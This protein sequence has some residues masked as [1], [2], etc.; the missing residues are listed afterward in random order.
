VGGYRPVGQKRETYLRVHLHCIMIIMWK[1]LLLDLKLPLN[2]DCGNK[3]V[4]DAVD[5]FSLW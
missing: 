3:M 5:N 1:V 4:H 2:R